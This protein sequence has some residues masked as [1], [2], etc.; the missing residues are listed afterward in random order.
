VNSLLHICHVCTYMLYYNIS[1]LNIT[2][3]AMMLN[4]YVTSNVFDAYTITTNVIM[5]S[6]S[7]SLHNNYCES[8]GMTT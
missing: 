2:S 4:F 8:V 5:S 7:K 6:K 3:V 1:V